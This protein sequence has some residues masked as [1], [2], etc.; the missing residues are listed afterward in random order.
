MST[1]AVQQ[2][3]F[4]SIVEQLLA[5]ENAESRRA[6]VAKHAAVDW[7]EAVKSLTERVWQEVRVD[8]HR[9]DRIADAALDVA[10]CAGDE[11]SLARAFRAKANALYTLDQHAACHRASRKS[12]DVLRKS[13]R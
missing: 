2:T 5:L 8:V 9:A 10:Q 13:R 12:G 11:L 6:F 3:E 4:D 1:R 7:N